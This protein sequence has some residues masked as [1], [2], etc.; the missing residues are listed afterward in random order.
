MSPGGGL[1]G[2]PRL[3]EVLRRG[4]ALP[5][6][7]SVGALLAELERWQGGAQTRDDVSVVAVELRAGAIVPGGGAEVSRPPDR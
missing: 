2:T 1:F 3:L 5:L 4:R 6:A 7:E